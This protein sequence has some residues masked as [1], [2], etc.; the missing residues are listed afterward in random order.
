MSS[1]DLRNVA[2]SRLTARAAQVVVLLAVATVALVA[3]RV[4]AAGA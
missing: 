1:V 2:T 4:P 3:V